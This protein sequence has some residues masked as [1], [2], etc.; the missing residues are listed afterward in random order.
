MPTLQQ[1]IVAKFLA[2]ISAAKALE[3]GKIDELRVLLAS[4]K[5]LKTDDLVKLFAEPPGEDVK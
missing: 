1:Q 4:G 3:A 5:K 2:S